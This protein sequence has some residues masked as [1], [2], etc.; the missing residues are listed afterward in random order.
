M[1][2]LPLTKE[3]QFLAEKEL[4]TGVKLKLTLLPQVTEPRVYPQFLCSSSVLPIHA[5]EGG[6]DE[7]PA[8]SCPRGDI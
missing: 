7:W 2:I 5:R 6:A 3:T 1:Y 4:V 8:S